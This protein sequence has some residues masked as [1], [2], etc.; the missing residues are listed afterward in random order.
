[1]YAGAGLRMTLIQS[2][3][4]LHDDELQAGRYWVCRFE[5]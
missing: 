2:R 5:I 3:S 1:V 4:S